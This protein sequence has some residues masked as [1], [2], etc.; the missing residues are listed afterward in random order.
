MH[1]SIAFFAGV[2]YMVADFQSLRTATCYWRMARHMISSALLPNNSKPITC[3]PTSS[4][5]SAISSLH[6]TSTTTQWYHSNSASLLVALQI[7]FNL[8]GNALKFTT[9]GYI[10]VTVKPL[11]AAGVGLDMVQLSVEDTGCGIA[12]DKQKLIFE[13]FGQVSQRVCTSRT[14]YIDL[15]DYAILRQCIK[16]RGSKKH[17]H[18][19]AG[20]VGHGRWT[21]A[22]RACV[23]AC[24]CTHVFCA[25]I[26]GSRSVRNA[27]VSSV[28]D[29]I[30][31]S[32]GR[33]W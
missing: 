21:G 9:E 13:A 17:S 20:C 3:L 24:A 33:S 4:S 15:R 14:W 32:E 28:R 7:I 30:A 1:A 26:H 12:K 5:L 11:P 6:R 27:T 25:V 10:R 2:E 18:V 29:K 23:C 22:H 16:E 8:L 19:L 31:L